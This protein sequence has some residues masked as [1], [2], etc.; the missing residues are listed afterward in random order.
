MVPKKEEM[1]TILEHIQD[2]YL[3]ALELYVTDKDT[4]VRN[5]KLMKDP[6]AELGWRRGSR[7]T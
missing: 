5:V 6:H 4:F 2:V 1:I 7:P 3:K